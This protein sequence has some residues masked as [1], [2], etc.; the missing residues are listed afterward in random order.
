MSQGL[1]DRQRVP[2]KLEL[3]GTAL[4][5]HEDAIRSLLRLTV[6][7]EGFAATASLQ[8]AGATVSLDLS[9]TIDVAA[10]RKRLAKDLAAAEKEK[11]QTTAKLGNEAFLAK[12]PDEVVAK[13]KA[14]QEAAE[15]DIARITAQLAALPQG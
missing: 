12:A 14:R 11:A 1:K 15:A 6:P 3:E 5:V 10:E 2:A 13:I 4:A 9:G 7:E 8:V